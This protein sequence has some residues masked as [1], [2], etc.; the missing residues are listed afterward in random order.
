MLT[1]ERDK[2]AARVKDLVQETQ[3]LHQQM[4]KV[5]RNEYKYCSIISILNGWKSIFNTVFSP[6]SIHRF[7]FT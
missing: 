7:A 4:N 5:S 6:E 1:E 2:M 3:A